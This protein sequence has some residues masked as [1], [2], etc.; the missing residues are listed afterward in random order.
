MTAILKI[1]DSFDPAIEVI[2]NNGLSWQGVRFRHQG[3]SRATGV[4]CLGLLMGI[5]GECHLVDKHGKPL[6]L[7]DNIAYGHYPDAHLMRQ[8]LENSLLPADTLKYGNILVFRIEKAATHLGIAVPVDNKMG[9]LHAYAPYRRV[10]AE[11]W[12]PTWQARL[13]AI[14]VLPPQNS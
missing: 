14:Y 6:F 2:I 11:R 1:C 9:L 8:G 5:A 12:S 4:D 7:S 10:V 13:A 3:R